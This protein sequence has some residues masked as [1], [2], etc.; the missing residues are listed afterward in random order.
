[1]MK[2]PAIN[3]GFYNGLVPLPLHLGDKIVLDGID[4]FFDQAFYGMRVGD[5]ISFA[6]NNFSES[7]GHILRK[8]SKEFILDPLMA[9]TIM[10]EAAGFW[11]IESIIEEYYN[12]C[13]IKVVISDLFKLGEY[14]DG[15][16][17]ILQD[18]STIQCLVRK[19]S[20][21]YLYQPV[22]VKDRPF[23][24]YPLLPTLKDLERTEELGLFGFCRSGNSNSGIVVVKKRINGFVGLMLGSNDPKSS[25]I[26]CI[27][28]IKAYKA[29]I[30]EYILSA[31]NKPEADF[32]N[33]LLITGS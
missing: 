1:M 20:K 19:Q 33:L 21:N 5:K 16:R 2:I 4:G 23:D 3:F 27:P 13:M 15:S 29:V 25:F 26:M 8:R 28:S 32:W 30:H 31:E 18:L 14:I 7:I 22:Y 9:E 11:F 12:D 6:I 24:C 10:L 17:L